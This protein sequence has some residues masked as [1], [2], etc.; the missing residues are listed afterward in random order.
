VVGRPPKTGLDA[1]ELNR[2][3]SGYV[4]RYNYRYVTSTLRAGKVNKVDCFD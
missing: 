3:G 2:S 4:E 1:V